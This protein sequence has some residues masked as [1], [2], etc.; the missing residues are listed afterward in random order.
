MARHFPAILAVAAILILPIFDAR[1]HDG[2]FVVTSA[3]ICAPV[4]VGK[5]NRNIQNI[6]GTIRNLSTSEPIAVSCP[7]ITVV[8][9]DFFAIL[10]IAQNES[11]ETQSFKC[12]L[13]EKDFLN[14]DIQTLTLTTDVEPATSAILDFGLVLMVNS[15]VD[16]MNLTCLLPPESNIGDLTTF[17]SR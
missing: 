4:N 14:L 5:A 15:A 2:D 10:V 17:S 8:D 1:A 6:R 13:R 11:S 7:L 3:D 9:N 12:V 16:R